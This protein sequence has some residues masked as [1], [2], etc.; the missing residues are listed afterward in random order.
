MGEVSNSNGERPRQN[1]RYNTKENGN[2]EHSGTS[3]HQ[4]ASGTNGLKRRAVNG[5][6]ADRES[7]SRK[8][9][10]GKKSA[11]THPWHRKARCNKRKAL[12]KAVGGSKET[13]FGYWRRLFPRIRLVPL[14]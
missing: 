3:R 2:V 10:K 1:P 13:P 8:E 7:V 5:G 6:P 12:R 11:E 14:P 4:G 9:W